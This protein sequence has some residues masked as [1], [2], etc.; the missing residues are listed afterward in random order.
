MKTRVS[1][2]FCDLTCTTLAV[3][4]VDR[5]KRAVCAERR[6]ELRIVPAVASRASASTALATLLVGAI[7]LM[8]PSVAAA[9][10]PTREAAIEAWLV[11]NEG[12][13]TPAGW[14]GR[15]AGCIV[16]TESPQSLAVTLNAVNTLRD[17]VGVGPVA[18]DPA[19]NQKALAAALMMRAANRLSHTTDP[20]WPCYSADGATG[21]ASSNLYLGRTGSEAM[22]GYV[23]DVNVASLGHRRWLLNPLAATFGTGSTDQTNA[24]YVFG[25]DAPSAAIPDVIAWPPAGNVPWR[26]IDGEWSA[27]LNVSGTI[28]ASAARVRV[29]IGGRSVPVSGTTDMGAGYGAG[30]MIK[31][32]VGLTDGDRTADQ[33]MNIA[34]D[35]VTVDGTPR[36]F[37]YSVQTIRLD[38]PDPTTYVA[39]RTPHTVTVSWAAA[40]EHGIPVSGYRIEALQEGSR[41]PLIDRTVAATE[42]SITVP[43]EAPETTLLVRVTPLSR[44]GSPDPGPEL[45][46]AP[47]RYAAKLEIARAGVNRSARRLSVLA[48]ITAR[49]SGVAEGL[50]SAAGRSTRFSAAIESAKRRVRINQSIPTAQA[51]LGTGILTLTY[52]GDADTQPQT[53]RMRAAALPAALRPQ[54]PQI[55]DGQ[56]TAT[57]TIS[58][59]A[60][61]VVRLQLLY[62]PTGQPTRTLEYTARIVGGRYRFVERLP[63]DVLAGIANRGGVVH[64]YTLFTG[65]LPARLRGEMQSY[66]VLGYP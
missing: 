63:A 8:S 23:Q 44:L 12:A 49:A 14:T 43:F 46:V 3:E 4:I 27:A 19:L 15:V 50:F 29:T 25:E 11:M 32:S 16:G 26:L 38:P 41:Q 42:R 18:L 59:S 20:S 57:G 51:R 10:P 2:S 48:P 65:Y 7:V 34:I 62:E 37:T 9:V 35:G 61:G 54:R 17:F 30:R 55:K 13:Q 33:T 6:R 53:V 52:R 39:R 47:P 31:W 56:M 40:A 21:A 22:I 24:L 60:R 36:Q 66:Q 45:R 5:I 1:G 64:S 28:D 58:R